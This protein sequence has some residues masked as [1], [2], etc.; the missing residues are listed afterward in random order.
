MNHPK[1]HDSNSSERGELVAQETVFTSWH[2]ERE[3]LLTLFYIGER[4]HW[5]PRPD[6]A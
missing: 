1:V 3:V 2:I 4:K 6:Q 5:L